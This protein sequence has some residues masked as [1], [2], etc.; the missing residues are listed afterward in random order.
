MSES[1]TGNC[2]FLAETNEEYLLKQYQLVILWRSSLISLDVTNLFS[3]S[4][5][6]VKLT[7]WFCEKNYPKYDLNSYKHGKCSAWSCRSRLQKAKVLP[8]YLEKAISV[9]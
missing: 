2:Q 6:D 1:R 3:N 9:N 7:L 8:H 5:I 4:S